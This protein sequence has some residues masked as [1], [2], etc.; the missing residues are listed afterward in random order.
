MSASN[1]AAPISATTETDPAATSSSASEPTAS[2]PT[3]STPSPTDTDTSTETEPTSTSEAPT[4]TEETP[5]S[6]STTET[7]ETT[8]TTDTPTPTETSS[9]TETETTDTPTS[10]TTTSS[11]TTTSETTTSDEPTTTEEPTTTT[12]EIVSGTTTTT[13]TITD[14]P[15]ASTT[16]GDGGASSTIDPSS[17]SQPTETDSG[18]SGLSAGGTIA[19]A[20]VVPVVSVA[21]LVLVGLWL[22][23]RHKAK[24][25][26]EEERRKEV[27]EYG[28]NPNGDP[29]LPAVMGGADDNSGYRG[30]GTTS[31]GRKASTNLSSGAGVGLA[32]SEAGSQPGYQHA[33]T[34]SDGTIQYSDGHGAIGETEPYGI[35]GAAPV[36]AGA[37]NNQRTTDINRGPS[38]ASSAY[39]AGAHSEISEESHMSAGH[40]G[41]PYY[42]YSDAQQQY[43]GYSDPYG[44]Q[45]VIRDVQARRNTQIQNPSVFPRQGNAGIAQNF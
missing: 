39:S 33:A 44:G 25:V 45:P 23:R 17:G 15:T 36:A 32:M 6:S 20:V 42:D 40:P 34:P 4:S 18:D 1:P 30:W 29:T 19:V 22:W 8:E 35:L 14:T 27:E 37:A 26:A 7:T 38:N 2:E 21:I 24:K 28:F 31:A 9:T 13:I 11:S 3:A 43:G 5:T 41:G 12:S 10:T 16:T